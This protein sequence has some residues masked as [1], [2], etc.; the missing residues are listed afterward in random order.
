M[1]TEA[2]KKLSKKVVKD[3]EWENEYDPKPRIQSTVKPDKEYS[4]N[5]ISNN[6]YKQIRK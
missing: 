1:I 3:V 4:F 6:L 5:E 2:L